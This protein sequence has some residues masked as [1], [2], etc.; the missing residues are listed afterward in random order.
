MTR[1]VPQRRGLIAGLM[2][3]SLAFSGLGMSAGF[4]ADTATTTEGT[5]S[6]SAIWIPPKFPW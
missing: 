5:A 4:A 6:P 1:S 3:L 2:V